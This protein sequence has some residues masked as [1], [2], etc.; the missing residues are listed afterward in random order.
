VGSIQCGS[1]E[2]TLVEGGGADSQEDAEAIK[3]KDNN[4]QTSAKEGASSENFVF[5]DT[6]AEAWTVA[7]KSAAAARRRKRKV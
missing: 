3:G 1:Q 2:S 6:D 4:R 5:E 7:M